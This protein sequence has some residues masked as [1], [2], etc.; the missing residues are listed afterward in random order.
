MQHQ[1]EK[2]RGKQRPQSVDMTPPAACAEAENSTSII[3]PQLLRP[4]RKAIA[5]PHLSRSWQ[6]SHISPCHHV[7]GRERSIFSM[8]SIPQY[9]ESIHD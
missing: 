6:T 8:R 7:P 1:K 9:H 4:E 3:Y 5:L 2:S